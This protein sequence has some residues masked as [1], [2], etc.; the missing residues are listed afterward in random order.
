MKLQLCLLALAGVAC[1][2]GGDAGRAPA[3]PDPGDRAP[4]GSGGA[5]GWLLAPPDGDARFRL[6]ARH[7]RG[8]DMAM[9]ETGHRYGELH[10]AGRDRNWDYAAYQLGKIET[11]IA[12]GLERRPK[13][14]ESARMIEPAIAEVRAAIAAG[15]PAAFDRSFTLLTEMCNACHRAEA[16]PFAHVAPPEMRLSPI[17]APRSVRAPAPPTAGAPPD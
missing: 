15:D 2:R 9:V 16:M 6:V 14:A 4:A 12:N 7:L 5:G 10:W 8:F 1:G 11:A 17:R 13:R 3:D